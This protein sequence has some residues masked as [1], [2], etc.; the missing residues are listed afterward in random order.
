MS[1]SVLIIGLGN[2]GC[3]YDLNLDTKFVYSHARAFSQHKQF[4]LVAGVDPDKD[5]RDIFN[6]AY[7]CLAYADIEHALYAHKPDVVVIAVPTKQHANTVKQILN[8]FKPKVILCEKPIS[9]DLK[10]AEYIVTECSE[11]NVNLYINYMRRCEPGVVEVKKRIDSGELGNNFKGI[12]WYSKGFLHNGSHFFNLLEYWLGEMQS[13]LILSRGRSWT[14]EDPEP[15]VQVEFELGKVVFLS[16]WEEAFSHYTVELLSKN[17]RL[18][19]EQGGNNIKWQG[20]VKDPEFNNYTILS[21]S[22][23]KICTEMERYQWHV[24]EQLASAMD[25]KSSNLCTG[26]EALKTLENMHKVLK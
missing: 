13:A 6:K 5:K 7:K 21:E 17:G 26:T 12:V 2:I 14:A 4:S 15:D 22:I 23:E 8:N 9:Y 20:I 25:G 18:R 3:M 24:V 1:Y 19:Y 10:E 16:A 11:N